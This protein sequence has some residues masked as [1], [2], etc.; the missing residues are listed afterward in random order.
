MDIL[1]KAVDMTMIFDLFIWFIIAGILI[2]AWAYFHL[3]VSAIGRR[4]ILLRVFGVLIALGVL[5]LGFVSIYDNSYGFT[6]T[7]KLSSLIVPGALL[8]AQL[9]I[10]IILVVHR[11]KQR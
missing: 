1:G 3:A 5:W 6:E 9:A 8:A 11:S 2:A 4:V 10:C 7:I